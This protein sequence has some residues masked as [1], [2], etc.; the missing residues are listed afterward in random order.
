VVEGVNPNLTQASAM[1]V[2][3]GMTLA[4]VEA[5]L[6]RGRP[7]K[8]QDFLDAQNEMQSREFTESMIFWEPKLEAGLVRSWTNG[9]SRFLVGF[10]KPP[11]QGGTVDGVVLVVVN[12]NDKFSVKFLDAPTAEYIGNAAP[13]K[14]APPAT[15]PGPPA[16]LPIEV[17][18][19]ADLLQEFAADSKEALA[20]YKGK[21][22][23]LTGVVKQVHDGGPLTLVSGVPG[24]TGSQVQ[25][26]ID[27]DKK[28]TLKGVTAGQ[29]VTVVA[30]VA[31]FT[32]TRAKLNI[33]HLNRGAVL[34]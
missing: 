11:E 28:D 29:T 25:V 13:G 1:K 8:E 22:V 4:E 5:V 26:S 32:P 20:K 19:Y 10:T 31:F 2:Q 34:K 3:R 18:A 24:D 33:L 27:A 9:R 30:Q 23:K 7:A 14:D 12:G 15:A 21:R 6:G 16:E 17:V